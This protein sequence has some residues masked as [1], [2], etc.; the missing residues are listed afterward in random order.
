MLIRG[1][2]ETLLLCVLIEKKMFFINLKPQFLF[3]KLN[4]MPKYFL[5]I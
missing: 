5:R 1:A 3:Q 2:G 4:Y